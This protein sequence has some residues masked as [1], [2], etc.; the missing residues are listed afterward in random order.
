MEVT[1]VITAD[2]IEENDKILYVNDPVEVRTKI[3]S[4]DC[5]LI[6]GYSHLTGENVTYILDPYVEVELWE[7]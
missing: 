2:A 4:G 7:P 1:D 5:I 3:D 6:K